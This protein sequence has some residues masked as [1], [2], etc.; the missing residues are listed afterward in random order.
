MK[1]YQRRFSEDFEIFDLEEII[2][3]EAAMKTAVRRV[4]GKMKKVKVVD[5]SKKKSRD[6]SAAERRKIGRQ[7]KKAAKHKTSTEKKKTA[8]KQQKSVKRG[9]E[10]NIYR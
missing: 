8:K 10:L 7:V 3:G 9:R 4:D 6:K 5:Y 2:I 1:P